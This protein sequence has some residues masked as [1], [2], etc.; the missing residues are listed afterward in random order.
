MKYQAIFFDLFN[1]LLHFDDRCLPRVEYQGKAIRTSMV[2]LYKAGQQRW[3]LECSWEDFLEA[4]FEVSRQFRE[5]KAAEGR[6]YPSQ[7]R[8]E[9]LRQHLG[10]ADESA[11]QVMVELHMEQLFRSIYLPGG[12]L[13]VLESLRKYPKVLASNFDHAPTARRALES[14]GLDRHLDSVFISDEVG[15][16]KPSPRF[17]EA[18]LQQTGFNA[19]DCLYVGDDPRADCEGA[20]RAGF[21][22]IW[23]NST[24]TCQPAFPPQQ[25]ISRLAELKDLVE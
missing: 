15:W 23:L 3:G 21:Q 10:I 8:F 7:R 25:R 20:G 2:E 22:V 9:M 11:S 13:E 6:E 16:I 12:N 5:I 19:A 24:S 18:I 1:T 4:F 14:F 17:F